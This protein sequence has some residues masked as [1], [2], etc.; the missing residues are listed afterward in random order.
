MYLCFGLRCWCS[1][2]ISSGS[3]CHLSKVTWNWLNT[4]RYSPALGCVALGSLWGRSCEQRRWGCTSRPPSAAGLCRPVQLGPPA[5]VSCAALWPTASIHTT[6]A[7]GSQND[8][9][10]QLTALTVLLIQYLSWQW[11][12]NVQASVTLAWRV[13]DQCQSARSVCS[14]SLRLCCSYQQEGNQVS[15]VKAGLN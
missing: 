7:A 6:P 9:K 5:P 14:A 1:S 11:E 3:E 13:R 12:K 15:T 10:S 8:V 2:A 4:Q